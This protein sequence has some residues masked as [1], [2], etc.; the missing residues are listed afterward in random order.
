MSMQNMIP[1]NSAELTLDRS[2][3]EMNVFSGNFNR[4]HF[5]WL[6]QAV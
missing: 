6:N 3:G 2:L 1:Q 5:L 4:K